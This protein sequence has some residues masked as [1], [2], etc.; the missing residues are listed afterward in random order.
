MFRDRAE[1][2]GGCRQSAADG[3]RLPWR[4]LDAA[5]A[6]SYDGV[7]GPP[8]RPEACAL[9]WHFINRTSIAR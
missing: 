1:S 4:H 6:A 8:Q 5:V 7:C 2:F 3:N 9:R